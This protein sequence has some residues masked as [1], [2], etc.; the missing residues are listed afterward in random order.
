MKEPSS[1]HPK[2]PRFVYVL[3]LESLNWQ[4]VNVPAVLSTQGVFASRSG[5]VAAAGQVYS[6]YY[7]EDRTFDE[8]IANEFKDS[9]KDCR[10]DPPDVDSWTGLDLLLKIIKPEGPYKGEYEAVYVKE[11][12]LED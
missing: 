8:L 10:N 7:G 3:I 12:S 6:P 1:D 2:T 5:A 4:D 11:F 9:H